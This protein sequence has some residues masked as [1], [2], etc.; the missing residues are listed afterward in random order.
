MGLQANQQFQYYL[1]KSFIR[2]NYKSNKEN[3][4]KLDAFHIHPRRE[5]D[6]IVSTPNSVLRLRH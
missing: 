6:I 5:S 2:I 4:E 1:Q 3:G